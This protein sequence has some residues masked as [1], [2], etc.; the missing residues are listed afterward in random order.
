MLHSNPC[1]SINIADFQT[2]YSNAAQEAGQYEVIATPMTLPHFEMLMRRLDDDIDLEMSAIA[3]GGGNVQH[4]VRLCRDAA[5]FSNLWASARRGP[6]VLQLMWERLHTKEFAQIV[7]PWSGWGAAAAVRGAALWW[8]LARH[9]HFHQDR[10]GQAGRHMGAAAAGTRYAVQCSSCSISWARCTA[11]GG[12]S[13]GP[14]PCFKGTAR[15]IRV[16]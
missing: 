6:D 9:P 7:L 8:R 10:E 16:S 1:E 4:L 13:S 14:G 5:L 15:V 2:A 11:P 12:R 3:R